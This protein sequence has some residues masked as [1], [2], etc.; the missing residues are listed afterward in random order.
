[1]N[2]NYH[3]KI[4]FCC[5]IQRVL[6]LWKEVV[7]PCQHRIVRSF[8]CIEPCINRLCSLPPNEAK[9]CPSNK[10]DSVVDPSSSKCIFTD[11]EKS[12]NDNLKW[13]IDCVVACY[14][15]KNW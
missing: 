14:V 10:R 9:P 4:K 5:H 12:G 3:G 1:M 15:D 11:M 2:P 6:T 7:V 8:Q 13:V